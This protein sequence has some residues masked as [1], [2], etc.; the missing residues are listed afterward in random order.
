M[1]VVYFAT[2][3][4][5]FLC[6]E[7][8][9]LFVLHHDTKLGIELGRNP[10]RNL[11]SITAHNDVPVILVEDLTGCQLQ[12]G[13]HRTPDAVVGNPL[14]SVSD[15]AV[16]VETLCGHVLQRMEGLISTPV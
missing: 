14:C 16:G 2:D 9:T 15:G 12:H 11:T 3:G 5:D 4:S 1:N 13:D 8:P 7:P 10:S 6:S